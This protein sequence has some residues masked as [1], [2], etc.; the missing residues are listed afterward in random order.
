[1]ETHLVSKIGYA[2]TWNF[3]YFL[4]SF[5]VLKQ[6]NNNSNFMGNKLC[7]NKLILL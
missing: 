3:F 6:K 4:V 5:K 7:I 1:M 2:E